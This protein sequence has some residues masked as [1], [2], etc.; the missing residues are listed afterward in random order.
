[1]SAT[2]TQKTTHPQGL[3]GVVACDSA[4]CAVD[5]VRGVLT[6]FGYD[7]HD[8]ADHATFEEVIALLW[9]GDLPTQARLD[10]LNQQLIADRPLPGPVMDFLRSCPKDA[11]PMSVLR[12]AV[13][14]LGMCD[15]EA[16]AKDM[17]SNHRKAARLMARIPTIIATYSRLRTGNEPVPPTQEVSTAHNFL[18]M[19]RGGEPTQT[20]VKGLDIAFT[21]HA[22]HELNASTFTARTVAATL[23]DFYGATTAAIASLSG[24][25]HGGANEEVVKT[26]DLIGSPDR[27]VEFVHEQLAAHNK[28]PGFG[29]RVYKAEDPRATHLREMARRVCEESGHEEQFKT[30]RIMEDTMLKEKNIHCNV[31]FYSGTFYRALGIP[32]DLFT[33]VFAISRMSGWAAHIL[34]QYAHNRLIRPRAE[35]VGV[36]DRHYVPIEQRS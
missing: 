20:E 12:T 11:H 14:L 19:L 23:A 28:I 26:L 5:G 9:D 2:G 7:I 34:E 13:S 6:Y 15:P 8:L 32:D 36:Y 27:A 4:I 16:D 18:T 22:D 31:D 25:L 35:Y 10:D 33:P 30:L 29:H 17:A 24:P 21:L 3:E 1:M